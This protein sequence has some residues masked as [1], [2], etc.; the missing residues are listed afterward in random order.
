MI[1]GNLVSCFAVFNG[2]FSCGREV[3]TISCK[4][5][6]ISFDVSTSY[7][8]LYGCHSGKVERDIRST[9]TSSVA[10]ATGYVHNKMAAATCYTIRV[11]FGKSCE[12]CQE[13]SCVIRMFYVIPKK[14][15]G[16]N[17]K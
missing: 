9:L 2:A 8:S 7:I 4:S 15:N 11:P 16:L 5:I 1:R 6:F 10:M 17:N 12:R 14:I 13:Y 3:E